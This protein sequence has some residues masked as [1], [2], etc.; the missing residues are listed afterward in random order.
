MKL[1]NVSTRYGAPMG[2]HTVGHLDM[3]PRS[4]RLFKVALDSG[5]Y[6]SGGA[7]WGI[8]APLYCA[9][10]ADGNMQF[11][12]ASS[13]AQA[14]LMLDLSDTVLRVKCGAIGYGLAILD[15]RAPMPSGKD[16]DDVIHWMRESGAA[17]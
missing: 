10:D 17:I 12:R 15:N 8:G 1:P 2:R 16:R 5:G 3:T 7:Y 11:T 14:A 9:M 4:V 6:D 13:R